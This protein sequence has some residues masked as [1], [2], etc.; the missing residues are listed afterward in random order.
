MKNNQTSTDTKR[1]LNTSKLAEHLLRAALVNQEEV[2]K[3]TAQLEEA[4]ERMPNEIA[5]TVRNGVVAELKLQIEA[6]STTLKTEVTKELKTTTDEAMKATSA[7][8]AA[9]KA[10][11]EA[12]KILVWQ[13]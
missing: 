6:T 10:A 2:A 3:L 9:T 1:T 7:Y 13:T 4:V 8:K 5:N 11:N 12:E